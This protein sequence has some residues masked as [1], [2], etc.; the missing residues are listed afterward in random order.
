MKRKL[1]AGFIL[2][3]FLS[4][5]YA[6]P[7]AFPGAEG[8]GA[9]SQGGRGGKVLYVTNLNDEGPG[10]L[11][12]AVEQEGPRTVVFAVSGI[13]DL[14]KRLNIEHP[15]ITIAGQTAPGD[16]IC[17]RGET[18]RIAAD[19]VII[20]YLRV[21][22]GDGKHGQ[23]SLQGKDAIGISSG[24]HI[25]LDHCSAGWSLDEVLS[26]STKAPNLS[27]VTVQW[28]FITEGLNPD[29]HGFGSLIRGTGGAKYSFLHNLYAHNRGRNPR[30]G[31][32]DSNPHDKDP[33]GLLL[34]FRNNVVYNWGGEH[35]A[36]NADKVSV[37]RLN[38]VNNYFI[39]GQD[40]K[41]SGI[42]YSTGSAYNRAYFA[43]NYYMDTLPEDQW[44]LVK[45]NKSWTEDQIASYKQKQAFE[46]GLVQTQEASVAYNKVL[47]TGGAVLPKRDPADQ[48]IV[49]D[50][51]QRTGRIIQSQEEVG[52]WPELKS[53]EAPLDTDLDGMPD[54][55]EKKQG[56]NPKDPEDRNKLNAESY[57][58]LE[59]YL[60][61]I[62]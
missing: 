41:A 12:A 54:E 2:V 4:Y 13:I 10:S 56:L 31:N 37:T 1:F 16:G 61:S 32:Y 50:V 62:N 25:I 27:N 14:K 60:N 11:R 9:N 55:W 3:L 8:F 29:G 28:C 44:K 36:Y 38:F 34:D 35:A 23:G 59:H 52:G 49:K 19:H 17:L 47:E 6:Q 39:P 30:P 58:M 22:L 26:A 57:T 7:L 24:Q 51:R 45:F 53:T 15:N 42:V 20:R 18:L 33:L 21:R 46:A 48:R 5:S 43:G 40:S